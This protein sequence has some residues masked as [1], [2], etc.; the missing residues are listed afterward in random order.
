[1]NDLDKQF[2]S[3]ISQYQRAQNVHRTRHQTP[4]SSSN[5]TET[6]N[7]RRSSRRPEFLSTSIQRSSRRTFERSNKRSRFYEEEDDDDF[8][9][10]S[11]SRSNRKRSRRYS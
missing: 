5:T 11:T 2:D 3:I 9:E 1:M 8:E 4:T 7:L 6:Y 10:P